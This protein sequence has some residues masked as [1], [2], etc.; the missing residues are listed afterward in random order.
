MLFRSEVDL[1]FQVYRGGGRLQPLCEY[2]REHPRPEYVDLER[3]LDEL[4]VGPAGDQ[5][6][7][8]LLLAHFG[9]RDQPSERR[10]F[11]HPYRSWHGSPSRQDS[12]VPFILAHPG[13]STAEL[14]AIVRPILAAK[15]RLGAVT[16]LMLHLR[17][18]EKD[19]RAALR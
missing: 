16:D 13:R 2:L 10:Y 17:E 1:P 5:A 12:E 11:S 3:R 8:V 6:G 18:A 9:D 14:E 7:D 19:E 15:P 4:A